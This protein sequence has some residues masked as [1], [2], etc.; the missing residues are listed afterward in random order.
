M[1]NTSQLFSSV[2][3]KTPPWKSDPPSL[4]GK[5]VTVS[6]NEHLTAFSFQKRLT[7]DKATESFILSPFLNNIIDIKHVRTRDQFKYLLSLG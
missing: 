6:R 4:G 7:L 2:C 5:M 3:S 1:L